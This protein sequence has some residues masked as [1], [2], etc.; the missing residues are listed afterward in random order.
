LDFG[1]FWL[2]F[3]RQLWFFYFFFLY[4]ALCLAWHTQVL[5]TIGQLVLTLPVNRIIGRFHMSRDLNFAYF[6]LSVEITSNF[7]LCFRDYNFTFSLYAF[8]F[9][10]LL[11]IF[12]WLTQHLLILIISWVKIRVSVRATFGYFSCMLCP[13][14]F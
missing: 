10:V 9:Y 7:L 5:S 1:C 3:I 11:Y 13:F 8:I 6:F 4:F 14:I 12:S 2:C